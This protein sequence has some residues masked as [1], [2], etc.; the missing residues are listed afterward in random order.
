GQNWLTWEKVDEQGVAWPVVLSGPTTNLWRAPTDN[1]AKAMAGK[2][3]EAGLDVL[4]ETAE[5]II[6]DQ[7]ASD[8]AKVTIKT[9]ASAP[10][11]EI[12]YDYT[13]YGSGDVVLEHR[14]EVGEGLPPLPRVGLKLT[15]PEVYETFRWYGRGP[16]ESYVD[17]KEGAA[18]DV[19]HSTVDA[20]YVP[21]IRPQE[22]G[23]KTDVRW[24]AL[25]GIDGRGLLAV[26][27]P[28]LEVSAHHYT[29]ADLAAAGHTHELKRRPEIE[30][31]LDLAQ[32]GLGSASCGPG[33]LPQYELSARGYCYAVR[34]RPLAPGDDPNKLTKSL[35]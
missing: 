20:E 10:G 17:R 8:V 13:I 22:F 35:G 24:A 32:S 34:L 4:T 21:Y 6:V 27:M 2:W 14:V 26:G 1:D 30:L 19:Y 3:R 28:L 33:V 25:T 7:V 15:L 31:H 23:N 11:I 12:A 9:K 18:V 29:A 16:H 5:T